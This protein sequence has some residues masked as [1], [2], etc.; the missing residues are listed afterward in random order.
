MLLK[1]KFSRGTI[2][3]GNKVLLYLYT[4]LMGVPRETTKTFLLSRKSHRDWL[5]ENGRIIS[6]STVPRG[7]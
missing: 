5:M 2:K 1:S 7:T 4:T 3:K 6:T